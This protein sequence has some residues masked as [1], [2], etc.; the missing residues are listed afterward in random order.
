[1]KDGKSDWLSF[2]QAFDLVAAAYLEWQP[3]GADR[4]LAWA[5]E[6][7]LDRLAAGECRAR[8]VEASLDQG[9]LYAILVS[10]LNKAP[11]TNTAIDKDNF[12]FPMFWGCLRDSSACDA[13]DWEKGNIEFSGTDPIA[14]QPF[15]GRAVGAE[16]ERRGLP[17]IGDGNAYSASGPSSDPT[18][19]KRKRNPNPM[20]PEAQFTR[21][22]RRMNSSDQTQ[23]QK[24]LW[25]QCRAAHP[26]HSI[27]RERILKLTRG[28]KPG[29]KPIAR[30]STA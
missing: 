28:R 8:A 7:V 14:K 21:W 5:R 20:L 27:T 25:D 11:G 13:Q 15:S 22:W 18:P 12:V 26:D 30:K 24:A 23:S 10:A 29:P 1:M 3:S 17:L 16:V 9:V 19:K 4:E 2:S 6:N